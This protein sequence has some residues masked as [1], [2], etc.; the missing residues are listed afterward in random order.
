VAAYQQTPSSQ[1]PFIINLKQ[2]RGLIVSV[3]INAD[4]PTKNTCHLSALEFKMAGAFF[5]TPLACK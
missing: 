4:R 5:I 1:V 3:P 2:S